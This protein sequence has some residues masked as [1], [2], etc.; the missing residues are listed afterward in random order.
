MPQLKVWDVFLLDSDFKIERPKRYYR[1]GLNIL[2]SDIA[3]S[4]PPHSTKISEKPRLHPDSDCMSMISSIKSRVSRI[5]SAKGDQPVTSGNDP[6]GDDLSSSSSISLSLQ[7]PTAMLD[8]SV[9]VDPISNRPRDE[10][11]NM[12]QQDE[13]SNDTAKDVSKHTFYVVNSQ[14]RLKISAHNEVCS[15]F[16]V[17]GNYEVLITHL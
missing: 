8:P 7:A 1:Q 6:S 2:N 4:G 9:N 14:M 3:A 10:T 16:I 17:L 15:T 5:F 13:K 11:E 12:G